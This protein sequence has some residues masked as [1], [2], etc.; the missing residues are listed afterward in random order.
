MPASTPNYSFSLPTVGGDTDVWGGFLNQNWST[1]DDLLSGTTTVDGIVMIN[2]DGTFT[3]LN[4]SSGTLTGMT[5]SSSEI[6]AVS[7]AVAE[8]IQ[9]G[10]QTVV[11]LTPVINPENGGTLVTWTL[12]A[13]QAHTPAIVLGSGRSVT[14][15]VDAGTGTI[16]WSGITWINQIP[17]LDTNN[18][19]IIEFFQVGSIIYAAYVGSTV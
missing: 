6:S 13:G 1:L 12:T 2:A 14:L 10:V 5:I 9:E 8:E 4:A 15:L 17:I 16:N 11:G 3:E 7:L 18:T 19:N